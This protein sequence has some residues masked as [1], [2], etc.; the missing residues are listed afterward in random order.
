MKKL[1]FISIILSSAGI[2]SG[3]VQ[4][5]SGVTVNLFSVNHHHG[6]D[7]IAWTCGE[8]GVM[9]H[10]TNGGINWIQQ[11][12]G[13]TNDLFAVCFMEGNGCVMAVGENGTIL[14]STNN[15]TN[16]LQMN[17]PTSKHLRDIS[18]FNMIAVGDS[19]IIIKSTNSGVNWSIINSPSTERFN[20]VGATFSYY[21]V[22]D[23]GTVLKG[24]SLGTNWTIAPSGYSQ[25]LYGVPLFGSADIMAGNNGL[26]AK[27]TNFG[28]NWFSLPSG[29]GLNLRSI[30]YSVNNNSRIYVCGDNGTIIK[31]TNTGTSF[32]FQTTP[33]TQNLNSIFFY[34]SDNFGYAC[35]N[36]GVIL[37]TSDGGGP[38]FTSIVNVT[39]NSPKDFSLEQ[40]YPNPFNPATNITFS[41]PAAQNVNLIIY[42]ALGKS[43][44]EIINGNLSAGSYEVSFDASKLA[45]GIYYY[46]LI[47]GNY[48]QTKKMI[49]LK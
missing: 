30:E 3:W 14:R 32:G 42:D 6:N 28:V 45:G 20:A 38:I 18:D 12:T 1:L 8:N 26:V 47:A 21:I 49:L 17:S 46:R 44:E 13:T 31:S 24:F 9:L 5:V 25:N 27:S 37:K 34:L 41:I 48:S 4:Q 40:N 7:D 16:W 19:G 36:N 11:T 43:V 23:N 15:G 33:T 10:T 2:Y 35:G 39:N 22:G 29:T